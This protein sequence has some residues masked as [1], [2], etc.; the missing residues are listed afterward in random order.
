MI[1]KF[2]ENRVHRA[3]TGGKNID[4][5]VGKETMQNGSKPEEWIASVVTA[6]NP[7]NPIENEGLSICED[8][9]FFKD[10]LAEDYKRHLGVGEDSTVRTEMSILVKVR[11]VYPDSIASMEHL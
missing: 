9:C 6:F 11:D 7:D 1:L 5:F 10:V 8:G 2:K 3:Y 4:K